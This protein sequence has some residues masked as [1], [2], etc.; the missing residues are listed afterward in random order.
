MRRLLSFVSI[1]IVLFIVGMAP[2][3]AQQADLEG[4]LK[5]FGELYEAGNYPAALVEAPQVDDLNAMLRQLNELLAAGGY[6][7][8]L[9]EAQKHEGGT[10]AR[11]GANG[12][13][14]A[15]ALS[16]LASV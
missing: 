12:P 4:V 16:I 7:A 13:N 8:A 14:Y 9:I 2:A 3:A 6:S 10:K 1:V 11:F 15:M 5:R